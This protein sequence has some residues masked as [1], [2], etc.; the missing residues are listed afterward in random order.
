MKFN[1]LGCRI[2]LLR[3]LCHIGCMATKTKSTRDKKAPSKAA[4]MNLRQHKERR[5][6][7]SGT[8]AVAKP[9]RGEAASQV[10][11]AVG[12]LTADGK[13]SPDYS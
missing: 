5:I 11:R 13:L 8:L 10:L 3:S 2:E 1:L 7:R 12:I 6:I 4:E 9:M